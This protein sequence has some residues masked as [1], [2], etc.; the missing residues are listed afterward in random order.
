MHI[1][2]ESGLW[3]S[4]CFSSIYVYGFILSL[5]NRKN[6]IPGEKDLVENVYNFF[7]GG[8]GLWGEREGIVVVL[9]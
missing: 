2:K 4:S 8:G 1:G 5:C 9:I 6:G 7:F 3:I